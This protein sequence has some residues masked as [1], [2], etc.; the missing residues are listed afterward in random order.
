MQSSVPPLGWQWVAAQF[1]LFALI[2]IAPGSDVSLAQMLIGLAIGGIGAL[3]ITLGILTLGSSL[4]AFP[5]PLK[6]GDLVQSGI[7]NIVRHPIYTGIIIGG[8]SYALLRGS[9]IAALLSFALIIFFDRKAALE[10]RWLGQKFADYAAYKQRV[11][12]LIPYLY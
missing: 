11:R 10:E 8:F 7:Y 9:W 6:D 3:A 5:R 1:V 2:L 12:K 4:S